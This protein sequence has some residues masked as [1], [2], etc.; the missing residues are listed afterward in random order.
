MSMT[1]ELFDLCP[2][3]TAVASAAGVRPNHSSA[4]SG[5][6]LC[7][8]SKSTVTLGALSALLSVWR[9]FV[10]SMWCQSASLV[11]GLLSTSDTFSVICV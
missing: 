7:S 5:E 6:A 8:F 1:G 4:K 9:S 3:L 2:S 10:S 11:M